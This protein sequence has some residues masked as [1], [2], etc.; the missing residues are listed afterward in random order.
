MGDYYHASLSRL[1]LGAE[2][3]RVREMWKAGRRKDAMAAITDEMIESI[4]ICGS[5]DHCRV[6][7][8]EMSAFGATLTLVPI[9]TEG[10]TQ[11]KCRVIE[12]LIA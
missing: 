1:G 10:S 8:N 9:P 7:L 2:A 11:E 6:R 3:D 5:L 4:A 12:S